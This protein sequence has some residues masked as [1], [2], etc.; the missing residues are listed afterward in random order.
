MQVQAQV[1]VQVQVYVQVQVQVYVQ[2]R[3][4]MKPSEN[5]VRGPGR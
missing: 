4:A 3:L 1:Q 5:N 2:D